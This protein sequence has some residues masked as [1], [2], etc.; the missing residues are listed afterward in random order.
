MHQINFFTS[1]L[2]IL[3]DELKDVDETKV[4]L[5]N[6]ISESEAT[7]E[8]KNI[9][10]L[11]T[12]NEIMKLNTNLQEVVEKLRELEILESKESQRR[13][14]IISGEIKCKFKRKA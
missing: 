6:R 13:Q 8:Q 2:E 9:Y 10:K 4:D 5:N 11:K 14:M 3:N 1:Q 7:I 12:E